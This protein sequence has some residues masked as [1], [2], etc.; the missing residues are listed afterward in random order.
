MLL[1]AFIKAP[2]SRLGFS[3]IADL[4]A[5]EQDEAF[6]ASLQVRVV[7]LRKKLHAV[8]ANESSIE[9]VRNIGYQLFETIKL[10]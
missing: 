8:G 6:K 5:L 1:E 10:Q 7:R 2:K 3:D 9:S 4:L